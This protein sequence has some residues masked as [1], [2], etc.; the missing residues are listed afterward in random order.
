MAP[1]NRKLIITDKDRLRKIARSVEARPHAFVL[2][3]DFVEK[4][5]PFFL[6]GVPKKLVIK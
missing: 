5:R 6:D 3:P 1:K 4:L 2:T